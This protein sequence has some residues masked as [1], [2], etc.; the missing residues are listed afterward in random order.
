VHVERLGLFT[1]QA[2][3]TAGKQHASAEFL[4]ELKIVLRYRPRGRRLSG[5][6]NLGRL[7]ESDRLQ[8][9]ITY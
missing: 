9:E 4:N 7:R 2:I 8:H 3:F 5:L 6:H 1:R